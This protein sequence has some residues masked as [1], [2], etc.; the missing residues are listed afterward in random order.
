MMEWVIVH[1]KLWKKSYCYHPGETMME[2]VIVHIKLRGELYWYHPREQWYN[3]RYKETLRN[4]IMENMDFDI[5]PSQYQRMKVETW[6]VETPLGWTMTW[7]WTWVMN[8]LWYRNKNV[9]PFS[10]KKNIFYFFFFYYL[11]SSFTNIF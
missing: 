3:G 1:I 11:K 8:D 6:K 4:S 5:L 9:Q 2:W 10:L 7:T